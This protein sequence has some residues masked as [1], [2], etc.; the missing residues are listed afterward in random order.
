MYPRVAGEFETVR[1]LLEGK[2][3]ARFGDGELKILEGAGYIR[4][5]SNAALTGEMRKIVKAPHP[6][7]LIG[8]PTM[9]PRGPKFTN[10]LRHETRFCKYF[11]GD[12]AR[13]W[14][15]AFVTRPDSAADNCESKEYAD[16]MASLWVGRGRVSIVCEAGSKLLT[17]VGATNEVRHIECPTHK[18]YSQINELERAVRRSRPAIALLSAGPTA[19]CLANRLAGRGIQAIDLGS[20]GGLLSRW[21]L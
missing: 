13:Q 14:Y 5:P 2:S 7:C 1:K 18:A 16:L 8:I 3:L 9:D 17:V 6:D 4:E 15:S 19:T 11:G 20:I 12:N 21:L 10:W